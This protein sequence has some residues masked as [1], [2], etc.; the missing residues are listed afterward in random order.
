[1]SK[2]W[3]QSWRHANSGFDKR[4]HCYNDYHKTLIWIA[5]NYLPKDVYEKMK[6]NIAIYSTSYTDGCRVA[7]KIRENREIILLSDHIMPKEGSS[8]GQPEVR[9]L[10]FVILHEIAHAYKNHLPSNEIIEKKNSEQE[11]EANNLALDWF[12]SFEEKNNR[13]KSRPLTM[14]EINIAQDKNKKIMKET[15]K[16]KKK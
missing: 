3:L 15:Y 10:I 5:L 1:M 2:L 16:Q 13:K 8:T 6:N 9:Y 12:N 4:I 14:E 11:I 7:K